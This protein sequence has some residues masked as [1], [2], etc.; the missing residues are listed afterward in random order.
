MNHTK[1]TTSR[2]VLAASII[3]GAS[4]ASA[5][6]ADLPARPEQITFNSL[7]FQPPKAT[8][9]RRTLSNGVAVYMLPS[10]EFPLVNVTFS[11]KDAEHIEPSGKA[12]LADMTSAM[13]RRGGTTTISATEFDES[14]EF[15]AAVIAPGTI[16]SLKSN[17]DES[18]ALFMDMVRN[19]AFD[20]EKTKIYRDEQI[21]Q[22]KQRNDEPNVMLQQQAARLMW[23]EDHPEARLATK[24]SLESITQDDLRQFHKRVYHP[25][26]LIIGVTGDFEESDMLAKLESAMAGWEKGEPIPDPVDTTHAFTPGL[27]RLEKDVPQGR[28]VIAHRGVK[29]DDP[30]F[31]PIQVMNEILGAGGFTSRLM[32]RIRS[33]EGLTYGVSSSF[34]PRV[35]YPGVFTV[36]TFSKNKTVALTAKFAMQELEKIRNE[37]VTEDELNT[38][39]ASLIETF[40]RTF[41]S[42]A[43]TVGVFINDEWTKRDPSYWQTYRD[44]VRAM[45][46]SDVQRVAQEYIK[47]E[48]TMMLVVGKW[49]EIEKGDPEEQRESHKASMSE[50]YEGKPVNALPLLDPLT[51]KPIS[52]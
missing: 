39:K 41:E 37:P 46:V 16:N 26:N 35:Y 15:L 11:F 23:G 13:M 33:D 17:F 36:G 2:G 21:E 3:A 43:G 48:N 34:Q 27:Y 18:F 12:G 49:E 10:K 20:Q 9:Y 44:R 38:A 31:V 22:M 7:E 47:P 5:A 8:D 6:L 50:F 40:P 1:K 14:V 52:D 25:G 51:L 19:P 4:F 45:T 42:K 32:K 30:D 24:E 29:R 28:F